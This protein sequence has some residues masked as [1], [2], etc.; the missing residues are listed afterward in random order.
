MFNGEESSKEEPQTMKQGKKK[1]KKEETWKYKDLGI[2][3]E[4]SKLIEDWTKKIQ[5]VAQAQ[6]NTT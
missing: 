1:P 2:S 5:A 3:K 6:P 4:D